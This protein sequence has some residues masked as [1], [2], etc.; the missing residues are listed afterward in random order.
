MPIKTLFILGARPEAIKLCPVIRHMK[1][2]TND[3]DVRVRV[4]AEFAKI[5]V[6]DLIPVGI[7]T[8]AGRS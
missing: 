3:F 6:G 4:T 5:R 8:Q 1:S 7:Q 2:R